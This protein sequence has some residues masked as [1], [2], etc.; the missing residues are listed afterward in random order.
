MKARSESVTAR[1]TL[2]RSIGRYQLLDVLG[3]GG[4]GTVYRA[5]Q[6]HLEK[7]VALKVLDPLRAGKQGAMTRFLREA[8]AAAQIRHP[9]V[10]EVFDVGFD[11]GNAFLVME[12][13]EGHDLAAHLALKGQLALADALDLLAPVLAGVRAAHEAGVV[14]RDLK[15]S[16]IFLARRGRTLVNPVVLDFGVSRVLDDEELGLATV[17]SA[18]ALIGTAA[19]VAPE[20]A[21]Q[22]R[23]ADDRSDQYALAVILYECVAGE[24]PFRGASTYELLHAIAT[25]SVEP[26]S[27]HNPA[28]PPAF[29]QVVLR[30]LARDPEQRFADLD[31]F[32]RALMEFAAPRTWAAWGRELTSADGEDAPARS[33]PARPRTQPRTL[34]AFALGAFALG[35]LTGAALAWGLGVNRRAEGPSRMESVLPIAPHAPSE[36]RPSPPAA[37]T[38]ALQGAPLASPPLPSP[39]RAAPRARSLPPARPSASARSA[40]VELGP[41]DAPILE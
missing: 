21:K 32:S 18:D 34:G 6:A 29:D 37:P 20:Q 3:R 22:S 12:L 31:D 27:R 25:A 23:L 2:D 26:P 40:T 1:A 10:V 4:M 39:S 13:L 7:L 38:A 30:A 15:P 16:N 36:A 9:N 14:H 5:R 24:R 19:Y 11:D 33:T 28:L 8:R 41:N 17:T 35:A